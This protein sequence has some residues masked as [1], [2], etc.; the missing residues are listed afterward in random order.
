MAQAWAK[1]GLHGDWCWRRTFLPACLAA[2]V[3]SLSNRSAKRGSCR[4]VLC[5]SSSRCQKLWWLSS[6]IMVVMYWST[7]PGCCE[8]KSL[9]DW[10]VSGVG[11]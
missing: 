10:V 1:A 9:L 7:T 3:K 2:R 8:W 6:S 11:W 4:L 5:R